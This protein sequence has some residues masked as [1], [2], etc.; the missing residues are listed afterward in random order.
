MF[1][2]ALSDA[3]GQQPRADLTSM[4]WY[5]GKEYRRDNLELDLIGDSRNPKDRGALCR[6]LLP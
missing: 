3:K 2:N 4:R 6:T 1:V 5:S